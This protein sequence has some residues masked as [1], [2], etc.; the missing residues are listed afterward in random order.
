MKK[1]IALYSVLCLILGAAVVLAHPHFRKV[2][3]MTLPA[4]QEVTITYDTLPANENHTAKAAVGE[5]LIPGHNPRISF[6][7]EVKAGDVTIPAG[8]YLIGALKNSNTDWAM[9]LYP[10]PLGRGT[11]PDMAKVIKLD[12]LF[13]NSQGKAEH[14]LIDISP[15]I[16]K[17]QNRAMLTMHFGSLFLG[18][19]LS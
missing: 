15:G 14:M 18:G 10:T 5:F 2:I 4:G 16:G 1:N 13:L 8:E 12:S 7:A 11:K 19:A 17:L 9:G 6:S 3:K